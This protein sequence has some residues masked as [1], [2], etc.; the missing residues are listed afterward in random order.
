M[1]LAHYHL[2]NWHSVDVPGRG[3][4]DDNDS[5]RTGSGWETEEEVVN[6]VCMTLTGVYDLD[7]FVGSG[8]VSSD[9]EFS[10]CL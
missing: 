2:T 4:A 1:S 8:F 10:G 5:D 9:V 6:T 7:M 3:D